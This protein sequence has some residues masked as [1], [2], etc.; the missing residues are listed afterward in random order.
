M[1]IYT[2]T[3]DNVS[4]TDGFRS[5]VE[6]R[7]ASLERFMNE[8]E[9]EL[10]VTLSKTTAFQREDSFRAE[11]RAKIGAHDFFAAGEAV[12]MTAAVDAAKEELMHE[13]TK[14]KGRRQTMF[15]RGARNIKN[16]VKGIVRRKK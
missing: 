4:I 13:V 5:H 7:F 11:V 2:I 6:K 9:R 14:R 8:S 10:F 16:M 12:D 1:L 15:H 3:G